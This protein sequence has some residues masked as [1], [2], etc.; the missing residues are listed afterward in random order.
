MPQEDNAGPGSCTSDTQASKG[1]VVHYNPRAPFPK[2]LLISPE[3]WDSRQ[4][5][6]F[7]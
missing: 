3:P 4:P 5:T 6:R 1:I 7:Q 2:H